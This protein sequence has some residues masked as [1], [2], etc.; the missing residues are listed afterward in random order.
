MLDMTPVVIDIALH[1]FIYKKGFWGGCKQDFVPLIID[2][3]AF[4]LSDKRTI[5]F[6]IFFFLIRL[7]MLIN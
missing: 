6:A 4:N 2:A 1:L 3:F 5:L 7:Q